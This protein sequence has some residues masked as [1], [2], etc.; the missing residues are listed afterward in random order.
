MRFFEAHAAGT[1][2]HVVENF[3]MRDRK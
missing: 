2:V 3:M 1:F